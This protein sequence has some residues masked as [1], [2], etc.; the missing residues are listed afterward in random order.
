MILLTVLITF[1]AVIIWI[2]L[3]ISFK[4][5]KDNILKDKIG[6]LYEDLKVT[7]KNA[8]LYPA[9]FVS[10]NLSLVIMAVCLKNYPFAQILF[11]IL[12]S[13]INSIYL[14]VVMPFKYNHNNYI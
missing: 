4:N 8:L 6:V 1:P 2:L 10:R 9:I 5:L 11:Y 7:S 13:L 12:M 14:V 3:I